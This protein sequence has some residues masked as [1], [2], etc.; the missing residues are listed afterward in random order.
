MRRRG[1]RA[2]DVGDARPAARPPAS[3]GA[4]AVGSPRAPASFGHVN[5]KDEIGDLA[6][7]LEELT[8]RLDAHIKLLESFAGDVSH[9]FKNPLAS[10]RVAAEI[11][12]STDDP[13]ERQRLLEMLTRDVD[14]LERLVSGVRELARIDAQLAHE[15]MATVD[16][17]VLLDEMVKG[18]EQR[19]PRVRFAS[20]TRPLA[21]LRP[22]F[23]GPPRASRREPAR[24]CDEFC[25]DRLHRR[26]PI[27][28]EGATCVVTVEDR[29]P[30][31][32][33]GHVERVF[34]RFFS[35][36]PD[37]GGRREHTGL[38]LSIARAIVEGYG[39]SI[40]ASNRQGGG[41]SVEVRLP[42][43]SGVQPSSRHIQI[44]S[45]TGFD[46]RVTNVEAVPT[47]IH[48][49]GQ[50]DC[51]GSRNRCLHLGRRACWL[52]LVVRPL[53][54]RG[55]PLA[56]NGRTLAQIS[57][58]HVGPRVDDGYVLSVFER[59]AALRPDI[60]VLTGD[61]VSYH[62]RVFEQMDAVY[63]HFPRGRLATVGIPGNH[64]YGPGWSHP[65]IADQ[66]VATAERHGITM[67]RNRVCEIE[68]LQIVGLDDLWAKHFD[69]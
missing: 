14:R 47:S 18:F 41:A 9:E 69:P 20:R 34:D 5:R 62:D 54:V 63:R 42:L 46:R 43:V 44:V 53:P 10:I 2:A 32:P 55:L 26:S 66:V 30:G 8:A 33:P 65:E 51:C 68:G 23:P 64:D 38:G 56:L 28:S 12:A 49:C 27:T 45:D 60:V 22:R 35:Y 4:R 3:R 25:A 16:V 48:L 37:E 67:L 17:S 24:Q 21:V 50:C 57:D 6:R 15:E 7:T 13:A 61:F 31:F 39:G 40:R 1:H 52:D 19:D 29:G 36:R 11:I 59:V 58:V